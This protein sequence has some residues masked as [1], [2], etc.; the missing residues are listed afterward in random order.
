M[1]FTPDGEQ[2]LVATTE[3]RIRIFDPDTAKE[4]D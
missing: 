1:E 3:G 2:L 4:I